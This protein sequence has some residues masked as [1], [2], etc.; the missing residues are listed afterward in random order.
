MLKAAGPVLVDFY[1]PWC[2]PCKML[3]PLLEQ[4]AGEFDG[5]VKFAKLNVDDAPELAGHYDIT[6]VPTL[7]LF[8]GGNVI[9]QMVGLASPG[10]IKHGWK[11]PPTKPSWH[12][13]PTGF[14]MILRILIG[15]IAGAVLGFGWYKLVGCSTGTCPLTSNPFISTLYGMVAGCAD[16]NQFSLNQNQTKHPL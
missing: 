13:R 5:R 9:D 14:K 16:R 11:R 8:R 12:D 7:M 3:A 10:L 1:A 4:L 15:A 6:G 2:G